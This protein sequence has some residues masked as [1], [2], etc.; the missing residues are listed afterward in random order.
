MKRS[1]QNLRANFKL[2][3]PESEKANLRPERADFRSE[4]VDYRPERT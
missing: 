4:R 3:K 2:E 1:T